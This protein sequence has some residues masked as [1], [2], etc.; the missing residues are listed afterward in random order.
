MAVTTY[1]EGTIVVDKVAWRVPVAVAEY[2]AQLEAEN[3]RLK[4]QRKLPFKHALGDE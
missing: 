3:E 2:V 4:E 1:K